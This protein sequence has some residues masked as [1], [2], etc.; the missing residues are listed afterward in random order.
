MST[1]NG[2]LQATNDSP[3]PNL[4]GNSSGAMW[5]LEKDLTIKPV[6]KWHAVRH[7]SVPKQK[8]KNQSQE[9]LGQLST[10]HLKEKTEEVKFLQRSRSCVMAG[11][12]VISMRKDPLP[13]KIIFFVSCRMST[14]CAKTFRLAAFC[15]FARKRSQTKR[16]EG[17]KLRQ[18]CAS[19]ETQ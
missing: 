16:W 9:T 18:F 13:Q 17:P 8:K 19:Y 4:S 5:K 10:I 11:G 6:E 12:R 14:F 7:P 1:T 2:R 3:R 15:A